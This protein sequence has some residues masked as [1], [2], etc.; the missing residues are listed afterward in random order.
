MSTIPPE[1]ELL[2]AE[3]ELDDTSIGWAGD[4]R[5]SEVVGEALDS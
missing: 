4:D 1:V 5:G 3:L 2:L